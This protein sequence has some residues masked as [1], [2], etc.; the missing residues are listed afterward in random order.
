MTSTEQKR[1]RQRWMRAIAGSK[2]NREKFERDGALDIPA[3]V[4]E[5]MR[6]RSKLQVTFVMIPCIAAIHGV[7]RI[8]VRNGAAIESG[9]VDPFS[10]HYCKAYWCEDED[11]AEAVIAAF[12]EALKLKPKAVRK[13]TAKALDPPDPRQLDLFSLQPA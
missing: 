1:E 8:A 7:A 4:A 10:P 11:E 13:G 3:L 9:E 6:S 12:D 2:R 5:R